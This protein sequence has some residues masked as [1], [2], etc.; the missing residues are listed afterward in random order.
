MRIT[1]KPPC[2]FIQV[3]LPNPVESLPVV[4]TLCAMSSV[5]IMAVLPNCHG[6]EMSS[7]VRLLAGDDQK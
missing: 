1:V 6:L 4:V 7:S 2:I 5:V 3:H